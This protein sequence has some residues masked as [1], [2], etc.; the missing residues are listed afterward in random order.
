MRGGKGASGL[1]F[2]FSPLS[3]GNI[4]PTPFVTFLGAQDG[5]GGTVWR[6]DILSPGGSMTS[7]VG[8]FAGRVMPWVLGISL[9]VCSAAKVVVTVLSFQPCWRRSIAGLAV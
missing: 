2:L 8:V 7:P 6:A 9:V 3:L 4:L 5:I 1:F